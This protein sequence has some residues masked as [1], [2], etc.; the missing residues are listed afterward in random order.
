[1]GDSKHNKEI[2][3][4]LSAKLDKLN[5]R[6]KQLLPIFQASDHS[7]I[8][9]ECSDISKFKNDLFAMEAN[10]INFNRGNTSIPMHPSKFYY[11]RP[12]TQDI[13]FEEDVNI[14]NTSYSASHIYE[15][16]IDG[17]SEYAIVF[18]LYR[19]IMYANICKAACNGDKTIA[20]FIAAG[21]AG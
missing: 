15:W 18:E 2:L 8:E 7:D 19:M 14:P 6:G 16:N 3:E 12:T 13:L 4:A 1:M 20:K 21:F 11:P 9:S 5:V 17:L 10:K